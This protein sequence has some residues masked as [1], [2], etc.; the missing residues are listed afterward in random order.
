MRLFSLFRKTRKPPPQQP[1]AAPA[2]AQPIEP[3]WVTL[4]LPPEEV[5]R[6]LFAAVAAGDE[7]KL[8]ALC[9][10]HQDLILRTASGWLEMPPEFRASAELAKW[11][12]DGIRAIRR[13]CDE[14]LSR[15][16]PHG[17]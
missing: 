11:Y 17:P 6:L 14:H 3:I 12:D 4:P 16:D 13:F 10:E 2:V 8:Q 15:P 1:S 5:R 9:H 7:R